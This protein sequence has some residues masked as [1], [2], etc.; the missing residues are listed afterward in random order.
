MLY[1]V[2]ITAALVCVYTVFFLITLNETREF[3]GERGVEYCWA[4]GSFSR[5]LFSHVTSIFVFFC[6]LSVL[7]WLARR[8]YAYAYLT[9][10]VTLLFGRLLMSFFD[11]GFC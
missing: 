7:Y 6:I 10:C 5:Y 1:P 9:V 4:Y 3:I 8:D 11:V 2:Y